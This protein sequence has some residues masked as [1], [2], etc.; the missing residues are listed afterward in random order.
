MKTIV[1]EQPNSFVYKDTEI[2]VPKAGEALVRIRRIGICGTD[3]HAFRGQQPFFAYPRILGHELSGEIAAIGENAFGLQ[4]GDPVVIVPYMEC[5]TCIACRSGKTNCCMSLNVIGVHSDGGMR[6]YI[7]CPADHLLKA[8]GIS[9][10]EAAVVECFCIG[11]HAVRRAQVQPGEFVLVIGAGP[12]GLTAMKFAKLAGAKVIAMDMVDVRL[13]F[14]REWAQADFT[15]NARSEPMR[16]LERITGRDYPTIVF[17]AA[18]NANSMAQAFNYT[19]NGGRLIYLG[20]V[21]QDIAFHDPEFHRKELTLL[22]SRNATRDDFAYVMR[23]MQ[24][25]HVDAKHFITHKVPFEQMI[26]AFP[27]WMNPENGVIKAMVEL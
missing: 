20:I 25:G 23:C 26:A 6:E 22:A 18:G 19:A 1:C 24:Q 27:S 13:Q 21:R 17:D 3:Y 15:V 10:D 2:P 12:I 14:C 9:L 8:D 16:E 4:P 11:A 7:A 5:G